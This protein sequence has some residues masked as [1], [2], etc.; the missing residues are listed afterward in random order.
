MPRDALFDLAVNRALSYARRLN[1]QLNDA[2]AL[3]SGL[4]LW[5]LK[6]RFAYRIPLAE[7][8]ATLQSYPGEGTWQGG[9]SGNWRKEGV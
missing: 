8:V 3:R 1:V 5:Y 6:T 4:E 7:V 2:V 9:R